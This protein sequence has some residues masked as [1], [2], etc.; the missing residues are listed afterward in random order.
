[1]SLPPTNTPRVSPGVSN[2]LKA[3]PK[4]EEMSK[5]CRPASPS[6]TYAKLPR[7]ET[8]YDLP[9]LGQRAS[10]TRLVGFNTLI[11]STPF[12]ESATYAILFVTK[13][14]TDSPAVLKEPSER[15]SEGLLTS[16]MESPALPVAT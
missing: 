16:K 14:P 7:V 13:T 11:A 6:A 8:S 9:L 3:F 5:I 1:M 2:E 12:S 15:I 4:T 10:R